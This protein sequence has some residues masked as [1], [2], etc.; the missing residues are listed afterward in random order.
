VAQSSPGVPNFLSDSPGQPNFLSDSPGQPNFP[1]DSPG[2]P[3]F[4]SSNNKRPSATD[5]SRGGSTHD[6]EGPKRYFSFSP[7]GFPCDFGLIIL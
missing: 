3:N 4:L 6:D 2:E 5:D 7:F 1:S